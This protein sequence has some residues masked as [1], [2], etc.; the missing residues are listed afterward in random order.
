MQPCE[1]IAWGVLGISVKFDMMGH[2]RADGHDVYDMYDAY[3]ANN[4]VCMTDM[5]GM[6]GVMAS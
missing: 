6:I 4:I 1:E 5:M 3:D 2:G